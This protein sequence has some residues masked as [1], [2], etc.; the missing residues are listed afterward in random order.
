LREGGSETELVTTSDQQ[1]AIYA[2]LVEAFGSAWE[3][4][5]GAA[6]AATFAEEGV[7]VASPFDRPLRGRAA[8]RDY[9]KDIPKEQAEIQFKSG[10]IFVAGP[11]FSTEFKCVF[12]RRRTGQHVDVRGA[13]FCETEG[14]LFTEMRMYWH[15]S[16]GDAS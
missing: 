2:A 7:F 1:K 10:E 16:S 8:I 14:E 11:W 6:I 15:R 5:D 13:I 9:W 12:R 3:K 4:G